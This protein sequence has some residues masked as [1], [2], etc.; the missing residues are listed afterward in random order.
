MMVKV[1]DR[2]QLMAM[3]WDS[4]KNPHGSERFIDDILHLVYQMENGEWLVFFLDHYLNRSKKYET[5]PTF[6]C[7]SVF[8]LTPSPQSVEGADQDDQE[9]VAKEE[10]QSARSADLVGA[11]RVP[12][13]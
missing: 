9:D 10:E 5:Y 3:K 2:I 11:L 12:R 8:D 4:T 1:T 6:M 7:G 13:P